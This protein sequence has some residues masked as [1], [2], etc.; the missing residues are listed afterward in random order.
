[1]PHDL[2]TPQFFANLLVV[3]FFAIEAWRR[4]GQPASSASAER[5]A[6]LVL[7]GCYVLALI[8]VNIP[9]PSTIVAAPQVVWMGIFAAACGLGA[10]IQTALAT[11]RLPGPLGAKHGRM[12]AEARGII[13]FWIGTAT[14][15]GNLVAAF[16]IAVAMFAATGVKLSTDRGVTNPRLEGR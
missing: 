7:R 14:A 9:I 3:G 11:R 4:R 15:S 2:L 12:P 8:A 5:G 6:T 1:M 10:H 13:V 16:T